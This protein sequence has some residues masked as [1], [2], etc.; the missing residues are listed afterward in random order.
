MKE[1]V[2]L[3]TGAENAETKPDTENQK[4]TYARKPHIKP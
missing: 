3:K 4:K 1:Q 2:S